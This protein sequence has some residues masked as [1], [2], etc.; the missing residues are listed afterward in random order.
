M[1]TYLALVLLVTAGKNDDALTVGLDTV[2]VELQ[3]L[4]ALV[5][6]PVV[7]RDTEAA[8]LLLPQTGSLDLLDGEATTLTQLGVVL[9][10]GAAHSRAE[11]LNGLQAEG[12]G[13]GSAGIA[14]ALLSAGLV[15]PDLDAALPVLAEVVVVED[16]VVAE[17]HSASTPEMT[18]SDAC[19]RSNELSP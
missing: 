12:S 6:P 3:A 10:G 9:E 2:N 5:P 1:N 19:P 14:S 7:N 4:L 11:R 17:T 16:V 15:K 18:V 8:G 13:L